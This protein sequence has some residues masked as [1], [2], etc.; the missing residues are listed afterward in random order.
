MPWWTWV[1]LGFFVA[2]VLAAG[3]L[4]LLAFRT[5]G[6][7]ARIGERLAA[8]LDDLAAKGE[9]LERRSASAT[10][11]FESVEPHFAHLQTT[12]DRFSVL[13]WALGDVARS[14]GRLRSAVLVRK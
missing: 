2:V 4:A 12:L 8:A 1:A 6:A 11:G 10:E 9:E 7:L 13:T 14:V 3:T 5:L